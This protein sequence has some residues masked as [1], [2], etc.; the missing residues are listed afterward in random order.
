MSEALLLLPRPLAF[1][2]F[3]SLHHELAWHSILSSHSNLVDSSYLQAMRYLT[4]EI[5]HSLSIK[6][7]LMS[8]VVLSRPYGLK[9]SRTGQELPK[10]LLF[11]LKKTA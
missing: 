8:G 10:G 3:C 2:E 7:L 11:R 1:H 5:D 4:F 6:G 9:V